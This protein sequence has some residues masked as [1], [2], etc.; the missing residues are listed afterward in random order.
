MQRLLHTFLFVLALL[1]AL[2]GGAAEFSQ[3]AVGI[4]DNAA[5][6]N[7]EADDSR[8]ATGLSTFTESEQDSSDAVPRG[9]CVPGPSRLAVKVCTA[10]ERCLYALL[11][12]PLTTGPPSYA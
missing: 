2:P 6:A 7:G 12:L 1:V 10:S 8:L 5:L 11:F 4:S 9:T 3:T